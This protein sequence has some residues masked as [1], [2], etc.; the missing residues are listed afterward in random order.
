MNRNMTAPCGLR[1]CL[2]VFIL[3]LLCAA[4]LRAQRKIIVVDFETLLPVKGVSVR[5]DRAPAVITNP[6]GEVTVRQAFDSIS[7]SHVEYT[8]EKLA[9]SEIG[10]TMYLLPLR[11]SIGEV[12]VTGIN[13]DLRRQMERIHENQI[14]AKKSSG[15]TFNFGNVLD[16]RGRRDRR[17][18]KQ[19]QE[20][21]KRW[22]LAN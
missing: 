2:T 7:F 9:F 6:L 3:V 16:R 14:Y 8:P 21:L 5:T 1:R 10:D 20:L 22:D 19:A 11:Y 12:V 18:Y 13:G 15:F 4:P 17:H